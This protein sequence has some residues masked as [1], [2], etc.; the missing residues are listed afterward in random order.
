MT[1]NR[2][3]RPQRIILPVIV[4]IGA[5]VLAVVMAT[6]S[7]D[8]SDQKVSSGPKTTTPA[9]GGTISTDLA[10][11]EPTDDPTSLGAASAP[12]V[13]VAYSE[14]Q[15]PFCGKFANETLPVLIE[16]YV[17]TG[18]VRIEW[19]DL[20]YLGEES[21]RA[22]RAAR[23]AAEQDAFWAYH[24]VLF[25][26]QVPKPNSGHVTD[27]YLI[28]IAIDLGLDVDKFEA[29]YEAGVGEDAIRLDLDAGT[30]AGVNGTPAFFVN[31]TPIIG[32]QPLEAFVQTI[33]AAA[34]SS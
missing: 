19:R 27:D 17:D 13:M 21:F 29:D 31:G 15:C 33:E 16:Q 26:D 28:G 18:V 23:A 8:D 11:A 14:F 25:A 9:D 7:K 24:D 2:P 34:A 32:A 10:D 3:S 5:L 6:G 30:R 22:A 1:S 4:A 20:P 12:V